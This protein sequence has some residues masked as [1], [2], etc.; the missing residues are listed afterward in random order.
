[1]A[2]LTRPAHN[3]ARTIDPVARSSGRWRVL[4]ARAL[5]SHRLAAA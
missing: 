2:E 4:L 1:M 5:D 3:V